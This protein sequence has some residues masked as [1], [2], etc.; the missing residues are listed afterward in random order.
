MYIYIYTSYVYD[1]QKSLSVSFPSDP[2][3]WRQA[4][5]YQND[6]SPED[7]WCWDVPFGIKH[8]W[9]PW[10]IE[11]GDFPNYKPP[12]IH[13]VRDFPLLCWIC[14]GVYGV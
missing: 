3:K 2:T 5:V 11:I 6:A 12:F 1:I 9:K 10:T 13:T 4:F 7:A 14:R 8:G